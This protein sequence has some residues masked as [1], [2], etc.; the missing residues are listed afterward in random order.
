MYN[1]ERNPNPGVKIY[2]VQ[3]AKADRRATQRSRC[4][5]I[6][7]AS[8]CKRCKNSSVICMCVCTYAFMHAC[9]YMCVYACIYVCIHDVVM[10]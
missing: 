4:K 7:A 9:K 1:V 6:I 2:N 8:K 3:C 10:E 5:E